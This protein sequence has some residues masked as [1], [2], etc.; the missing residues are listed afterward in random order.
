MKKPQIKIYGVVWFSQLTSSKIIGII[1][2]NTGYKDKAYI[3][4]CD[5][6]DEELDK[7]NLLTN[8]SPFPFEQA[9]QLT[10]KISREAE[11]RMKKTK[12]T[13]EILN[14]LEE[15]N[16]RT[17]KIFVEDDKKKENENIT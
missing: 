6:E 7:K 16:E 1:T 13:N 11:E 14:E 8:G 2:M 10:G 4:V 12:E 3:G 5:G 17:L 15:N 9:I